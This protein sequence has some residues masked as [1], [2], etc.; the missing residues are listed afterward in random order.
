MENGSS[1]DVALGAAQDFVVLADADADK[2]C[3]LVDMFMLS[4]FFH[5][6]LNST[7]SQ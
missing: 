2:D 6:T 4:L 7:I 1:A 5:E 3:V